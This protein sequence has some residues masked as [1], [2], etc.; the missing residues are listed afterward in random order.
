MSM[1]LFIMNNMTEMC[2]C[3]INSHGI[4]NLFDGVCS[5]L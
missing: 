3:E 2:F 5:L 4:N 1:K